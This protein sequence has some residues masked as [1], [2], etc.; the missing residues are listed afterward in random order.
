MTEINKHVEADTTGEHTARNPSVIYSDY[1]AARTTLLCSGAMSG[2][3]TV[4]SFFSEELA[5]QSYRTAGVA[6]FIAGLF[7]S[8][9]FINKKLTNITPSGEAAID[10]V[11]GF[12]IYI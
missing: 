1:H 2:I 4:E 7:G 11:R 5:I 6:A 3:A 8:V 10:N 9:T 12:S